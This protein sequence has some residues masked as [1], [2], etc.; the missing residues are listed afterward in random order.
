MATTESS[1]DG[2]FI[3]VLVSTQPPLPRGTFRG[4]VHIETDHLKYP[5]MDIAVSA[6]VVGDITFAPEELPVVEQAGQPASRYMLVRSETGKK[7]QIVTVEVPLPSMTYKI[8]PVETG[9]YQV[10][11]SNIPATR[12]IEGK[13]LRIK[14]DL[15][16]AADIVIPFRFIPAAPNPPS[17]Q[18][19]AQDRN[20]PAPHVPHSGHFAGGRRLRS[21][22]AACPPRPDSLV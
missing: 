8:Q 1:S 18:N 7:F 21:R 10:E 4:N 15:Q 20:N 13:E 2:K 5:A 12:E 3:R 11:L 16:G 17:R 14:T 9:G 19:H 6:F 22:L